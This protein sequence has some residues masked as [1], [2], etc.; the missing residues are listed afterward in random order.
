MPM[1]ASDDCMDV[2]ALNALYGVR[3][4][5]IRGAPSYSISSEIDDQI[6]RLREPLP[7][8]GYR[9]VR[10]VRPAGGEG[11]YDR[12]KH[13][14]R[15]SSEESPDI[16]EAEA[17]N[18][19]A[20]SIV[21]PRKRSLFRGNNESWIGDATISCTVEGRTETRRESIQRWMQADT[22]HT[23]DFGG[24]I[25]DM[26]RVRLETA[27]REEFL[28]EEALVEIHIREA[29]EEDDPLNPN[30]DTIRVLRK[31]RYSASPET[32]DYEI[33]KLERRLFPNLHSYPFATLL[34]ETREAR[35]LLVSDEEEDRDKGMKM[36]ENVVKEL[37]Q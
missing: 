3:E 35:R 25:A 9:W 27:T 6:T 28:D 20:V 26:C 21:V 32:L 8:G 19:W 15:S 5:V 31:L 13:F 18:A 16:F 11:P 12:T 37:E 23:I 7:G 33:A 4:L 10:L 17:A 22:S 14:V 34:A 1:A 30:A 24:P 2:E 36:L 29:V